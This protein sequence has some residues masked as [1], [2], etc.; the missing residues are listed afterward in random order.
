M[1]TP[2]AAAPACLPAAADYGQI[3]LVAAMMNAQQHWFADQPGDAGGSQQA[4]A[5][6]N[7]P[8]NAAAAAGG[9]QPEAKR[10]RLDS[11]QAGT[12]GPAQPAAQLLDRQAVQAWIAARGAASGPQL[13]EHFGCAANGTHHHHQQMAA[14]LEAMCEDF[15]VARRGGTSATSAIIDL[16]DPTVQFVA[17]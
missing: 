4:A 17:L 11:S 5:G 15:D 1:P 12:A 6:E 13:L 9:A 16:H 2:T 7:V 8:D 10:A 3:K 14:L